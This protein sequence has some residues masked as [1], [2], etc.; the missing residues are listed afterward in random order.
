M[1]PLFNEIQSLGVSLSQEDFL[2]AGLCLINS[3]T[4]NE[5]HELISKKQS[6]TIEMSYGS[7][8]S[9]AFLRQ[10]SGDLYTRGLVKNK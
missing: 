6:D 8:Q 7:S 5:K 2:E 9:K 4:P 10:S 1:Y 3:L